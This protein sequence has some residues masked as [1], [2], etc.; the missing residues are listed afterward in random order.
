M[1]LSKSEPQCMEEFRRGVNSI[2]DSLGAIHSPILELGLVQYTLNA[3][4]EDYDGIVDA[5][6]YILGTLTFDDVCTKLL[7]YE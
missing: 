5:L 7:L 4:D 1:N 2:T 6:T 3:L